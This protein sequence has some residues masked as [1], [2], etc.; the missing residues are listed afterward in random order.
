MTAHRPRIG[1]FGLLGSGNIGN[2][3]QMESMLGYLR[4]EHP[5]SIIDAMCSGP[6][7]MRRLYS[8]DAIPLSWS[9]QYE[10]QRGSRS[11][12]PKLLGKVIDTVRIALWVRRHDV[13]IVPGM[14]VLETTLPVRAI[15]SPC[16]MFLVSAAG[17]VF[18]TKVALVS[19]G[20]NVV[21]QGLTRWLYKS[22]A[23]LA[24]Y[25]SYRDAASRDAMAPRGSRANDHVFTDLAFGVPVPFDT[26]GDPRVVG[27]G[28]MDFHGTNDERD[29]SEEIYQRYLAGMISFIRWLVD[30]GR[31]VRLF[32]GDTKGCDDTV[33]SE[34]MA[35]L[36][37]HRPDLEPGRVI[38]R[39]TESFGDL[40]REIAPAGS[41]VATRYHNV[42]CALRLA[43]PTISVGYAAKHNDLME[44]MGM[45]AFCQLAQTL[46]TALLIQQFAEL[47]DRADQVRE[48]IKDRNEAQARLLAGQFALLS[49]A[50]LDT[51]ATPPPVPSPA[52]S[53]QATT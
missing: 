47:E 10:Q 15:G 16:A 8:V 33:I 43:K 29:R 45:S 19:V 2:D 28:V 36:K 52:D 14:G 25:R 30:N 31:D 21:N 4:T 7:R 27:I 49:T 39:P 13:V 35:D 38:A 46:D 34:I 41:V 26:P 3:A 37:L 32:V 51:P 53:V 40:L 6:E 11:V 22:A 12:V 48:M 1:L 17:R 9:T 23:R 20:A 42:I 50:L 5:E 44:K 24:Y 18:R